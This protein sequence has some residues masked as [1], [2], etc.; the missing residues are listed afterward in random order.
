MRVIYAKEQFI[1]SF[2]FFFFVSVFFISS[3]LKLH[4]NF[5]LKKFDFTL[6]DKSDPNKVE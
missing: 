2:F 3:R 6:L 1:D 5:V 4:V